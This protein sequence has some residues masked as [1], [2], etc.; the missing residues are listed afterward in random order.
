MVMAHHYRHEFFHEHFYFG[1]LAVDLFFVLSGVVLSQ[2]YSE[3]LAAGLNFKGFV[4]IRLIRLYPMYLAATLIAT[5]G[6]L[7][8]IISG[9]KNDQFT[10]HTLLGSVLL[11]LFMLPTPFHPE[12]YPIVAPAWSLAYELGA[13]FLWAALYIAI[14][15]W[16]YFVTISSAACGLLVFGSSGHLSGG[17]WGWSELAM[18][19]CRVLYSFGLGLLIHR[20]DKSWV[21]KINPALILAAVTLILSAEI[22]QS[23]EPAFKLGTILFLMPFIVLLGTVSEP[24]GFRE[25]KIYT[26]FGDAS[27][28]IY[29]LHF[30]VLLFSR[31]ILRHFGVAL[32]PM[33]GFLTM[34]CVV[35]LAA[36][37]ERVWDRPVRRWLSANLERGRP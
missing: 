2:A 28:G 12:L 34:A 7:T 3:R 27:Y 21:P 20:M 11:S 33:F 13:N 24:R 10:Y 17:F 6:K 8:V 18:G 26:F 29:L 30:S 36:G 31:G 37:L 16:V 15:P 5:W 35:A 23:F 4:R 1:Y 9:I 14:K 32:S 22:P 19:T 25:S